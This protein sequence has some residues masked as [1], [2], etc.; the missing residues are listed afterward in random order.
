[1]SVRDRLALHSFGYRAAVSVTQSHNTR[2]A[3]RPILMD[4]SVSE[5]S[6]ARDG[7]AALSFVSSWQP[8]SIEQIGID[9][10]G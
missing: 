9:R 7:T 4:H 2:C 8:H 3:D 6:A 1:M 5:L 10:D